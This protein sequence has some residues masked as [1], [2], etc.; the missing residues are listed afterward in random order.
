MGSLV[1]RITDWDDSLKLAGLVVFLILPVGLGSFGTNLLTQALIF[2]IFAISVDLLWGYGGILTFG[3]AAFFGLGAYTTAKLLQLVPVSGIS[4]I[5]LLMGV[6]V[7]ALI[8]LLIA[9]VLF[10]RDIRGAYFTIITLAIAIIFEQV[11]VSWGSVT[12]GYNGLTA[13]PL[14]KVGIPFVAMISLTPLLLY[15]VAVIGLVAVFLFGRRFINSPFGRA[16]IAV[17]L[18]EDKAK[19]LGY[20]TAKYKTGLFVVACGVAGFAGG[21][22]TSYSSFISPQVAGFVLSTEVLVWVLVGG[23]GTL[24]GPVVGTIFLTIFENVLSGIFAFTWTLF[25][26]LLLVLI[27]LLFPEGLVK[28]SSIAKEKTGGVIGDD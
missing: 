23:R 21:L 13:I 15:Y 18:N 25:V 2:A 10:Y 16:T 14:L 20:N 17:N 9:G 4:Y 28:I 27:V 22:Y 11:A 6:L 24:I 8:G 7:P 19:A 3:H 1:N 26:G 12:G 5:A